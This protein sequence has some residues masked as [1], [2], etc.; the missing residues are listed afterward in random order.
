MSIAEHYKRCMTEALDGIQQ[1]RRITDDFIAY[2]DTF[3]AHV[4]HVWDIL[5]G[6]EEKGISLSIQ[7]FVFA[8]QETKFSGYVLFIYGY[9]TDPQITAAISDYPRP[10]N[11]T[12]LCSFRGLVDQLSEFTDMISKLTEP[13]RP[14][15]KSKNE[16]MWAI[17]HEQAF[18]KT[19]QALT[20]SPILAYYDPRKTTLLHV[21]ASRYMDLD[22]C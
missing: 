3:E 11:I 22:S 5:M 8:R 19:K 12:D 6:S 21:D 13:L 18:N 2:D 10:D 4:N 14:L 20:S 7:K 1:I 17:I 16:F 15:L 9:R